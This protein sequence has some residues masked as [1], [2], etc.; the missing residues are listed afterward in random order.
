[1]LHTSSVLETEV[2]EERNYNI[3]KLRDRKMERTKI[4]KN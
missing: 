4:E 1:M 3:S 2:E